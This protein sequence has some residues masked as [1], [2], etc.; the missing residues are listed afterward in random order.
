MKWFDSTYYGKSTNKDSFAWVFAYLFIFVCTC[1]VLQGL[2][3][4]LF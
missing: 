2:V 4:L 1:A 3:R